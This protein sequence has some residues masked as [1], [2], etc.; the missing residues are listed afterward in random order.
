MFVVII[1]YIFSYVSWAV[2]NLAF[3]LFFVTG[4]LSRSFSFN[5]SGTKGKVK[6]FIEKIPANL[7]NPKEIS[8]IDVRKDRVVRTMG[9]SASFRSVGSGRPG[10]EKAIKIQ[11]FN[12]PRAEDS[13]A[14]KQLKERNSLEKK[15]SFKLDR[16]FASP[17]SIL[18]T[19]VTSKS[20]LK[21]SPY[22]GKSNNMSE[23]NNPGPDKGSEDS[24][25]TGK[26][27]F[28]C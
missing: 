5:N 18:N 24:N 19:G 2:F 21:P 27:I 9:K 23:A 20:E 3:E 14:S 25:D 26:Q 13:R 4:S 17:A 15:S 16:T 12:S 8:P 10:N 22:H 28:S 11:P 1:I 7:K 6:Q